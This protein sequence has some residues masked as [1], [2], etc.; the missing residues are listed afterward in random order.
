MGWRGMVWFFLFLSKIDGRFFFY[1]S[2]VVAD[3]ACMAMPTVCF[4]FFFHLFSWG[5]GMEC[6]LFFCPLCHP[7]VNA[8][9]ASLFHF[10]LSEV[11]WSYVGRLGRGVCVK[12]VYETGV[13]CYGLVFLLCYCGCRAIVSNSIVDGK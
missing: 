10:A 5:I 13:S 2:V 11:G 9:S 4:F 1:G 7:W 6:R 3:Y 8:F 12:E